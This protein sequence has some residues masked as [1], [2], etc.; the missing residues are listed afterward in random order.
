MNVRQ[1]SSMQRAVAVALVQVLLVGSVG[2]KFV[3]DRQQYPRVWVRTVPFDPDLPIR[4]RYVRLAAVVEHEPGA[5]D[6][7]YGRARLAV[8]DDKLVAVA[9][10]EGRHVITR[11]TCGDRPCWSLQEPLAFFIPEH[12]ADPSIRQPG[13]ELW[14]EVTVPPK[15]PPRPVKLGVYSQGRL[16]PLAI[17]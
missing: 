4:G 1:W 12:V 10:E 7:E 13:E 14:V 9:D 6:L 8:H 15:G 17:R 5:P 11:R 2:L 3:L 16:A